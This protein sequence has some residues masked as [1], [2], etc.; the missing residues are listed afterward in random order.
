MNLILG[1]VFEMIFWLICDMIN[2]GLSRLVR[3]TI[4]TVKTQRGCPC[5]VVRPDI[6]TGLG[7]DGEEAVQSAELRDP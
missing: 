2:T 1:A 3:F 7:R 5:A 4:N 6:D